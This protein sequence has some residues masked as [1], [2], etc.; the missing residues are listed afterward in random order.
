MLLF[1]TVICYERESIINIVYIRNNFSDFMDFLNFN[2]F[3]I[4]YSLSIGVGENE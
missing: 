1:A 4:F 3:L 2:Y